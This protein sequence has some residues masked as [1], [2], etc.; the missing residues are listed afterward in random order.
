MYILFKHSSDSSTRVHRFRL[1]FPRTKQLDFLS[2][3][4]VPLEPTKKPVTAKGTGTLF[5]RKDSAS[6]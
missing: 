5:F 6:P 2:K 1:Y 3:L 4:R